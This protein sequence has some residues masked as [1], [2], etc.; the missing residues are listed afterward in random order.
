MNDMKSTFLKSKWISWHCHVAMS[1]DTGASMCCDRKAPAACAQELKFWKEKAPC[2]NHNC[3]ETE[4]FVK[5]SC[6]HL[7]STMTS[8]RHKPEIACVV[9][10]SMLHH[11]HQRKKRFRNRTIGDT[12][13]DAHNQWQGTI[14]HTNLHLRND[15]GSGYAQQASRPRF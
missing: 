9:Y 10:S 14:C 4:A 11:W 8:S 2:L 3:Q 1:K 12:A 15:N 7:V 6:C 5:R 13:V